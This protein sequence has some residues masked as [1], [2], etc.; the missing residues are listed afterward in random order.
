MPAVP[1]SAFTVPANTVGIGLSGYSLTGS[2]AQ[3]MLDLAGTW[4]TTGTPTALKLNVTDTASNAASLLMDLQV[5]GVSQFSVRKDGLVNFGG[6]TK[7]DQNGTVFLGTTTSMAQGGG[8]F[9]LG[10]YNNAVHLRS[11][12]AFS[13]SPTDSNSPTQDLALFRDAANTLAQRNGVNAQTLRVYNTFTSSTNFQRLAVTSATTTLSAL[14]GASVTATALIPAGAVVVGV[15]TRVSTEITGATGYQVGT[16]ADPDRWGDIT[17][18]AVGTTS[19]NTN[20]TA[21][22][23]ECFTAASDVVITAKTSNFTAGA[24]SVTVHYLIGQAD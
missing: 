15:T 22:T 5:G 8:N 17:G 21:G 11:T 23:I 6:E 4:N 7:V 14:S 9:S 12:W 13:W 3:S 10:T 16:V 24:I 18:V 2:N 20:W 1:I 19:D